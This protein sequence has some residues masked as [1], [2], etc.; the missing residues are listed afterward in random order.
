MCVCVRVCACTAVTAAALAQ[1]TTAAFIVTVLDAEAKRWTINIKHY[2][3]RTIGTS[4]TSL[5]Q[6]SFVSKKFTVILL[7]SSYF[8]PVNKLF[9]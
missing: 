1:E 3:D 7:F 5:T 6:L 9:L 4:L 8:Q 2:K